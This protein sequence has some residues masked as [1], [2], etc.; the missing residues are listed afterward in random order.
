MSKFR[1][2]TNGDLYRV[3]EQMLPFI[4]KYWTREVGVDAYEY[5]SYASREQAANAIQ[6]H[7]GARAKI[8]QG[9]RVC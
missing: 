4:W 5:I 2:L 6:K 9:W 7:A 8:V 3:Q 1:I